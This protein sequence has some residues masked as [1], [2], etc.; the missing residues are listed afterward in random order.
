MLYNFVTVEG[1]IGVGKTTLASLF[2][3][4]FNARLLLERFEENP[5]LERFYADK[6]R[7]AF[8]TE[9]G[10]MADRYQQLSGFFKPDIFQPKIVSDYAS[11]KSL[12]FAKQNLDEKEFHLYRQFYDISFRATPQADIILHLNRPTPVLLELIR[13]R[14]R[15]FEQ[16]IDAGYLSE[17]KKSY[18]Q[19]YTQFSNTKTLIVE[20]GDL[21]FIGDEAI[22]ERLKG[23]LKKEHPKGISYIDL[24]KT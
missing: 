22:Y 11:F 5:F 7:Y 6:K 4:D 23:L 3:R 18:L 13:Q 2:A 10:F 21:D 8:A 24:N 17:L 1:S 19:Y 9:M 12:I 15:N 16:E 14:G 20:L